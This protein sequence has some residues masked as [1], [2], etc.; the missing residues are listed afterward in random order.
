MT[1]NALPAEG[2]RST[3]VRVVAPRGAARE[4]LYVDGAT[5]RA[6]R[7]I[8]MDGGSW[9]TVEAI[10]DTARLMDE[11]RML[12]LRLR[13]AGNDPNG[14]RQRL[15]ALGFKDDVPVNE[16][17]GG[18]G[19]V[20]HDSLEASAQAIHEAIAC[21]RWYQHLRP[22]TEQEQAAETRRELMVSRSYW[23]RV[24]EVTEIHEETRDDVLAGTTN[25][26][27]QPLSN[28][29]RMAILAY[30][31]EPSLIAW[32]DM[33]NYLVTPSCTLWQA[34]IAVDPMAPKTG[35]TRAFPTAPALRSAIRAAV[36]NIRSRAYRELA[37]IDAILPARRP[38]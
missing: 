25:G 16:G 22:L 24:L 15:A 35:S 19:M 12:A 14:C 30:L 33:R 4:Y 8:Q 3:M 7:T 2:I 9:F 32:E 34:W 13:D 5:G 18:L 26:T 17:G 36:E 38:S 28:E 21:N 31:H 20:I 10:P 1:T 23:Q 11:H 6:F 27:T 29:V 37:R